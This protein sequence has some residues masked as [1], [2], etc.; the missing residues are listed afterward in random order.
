MLAANYTE[1]RSSMKKFLD[2]VENRNQTILIKRGSS[3]GS[4][5]MS[6]QEY[7]SLI[8][9]I[10]LLKSKANAA[11]LFESIKQIEEGNIITSNL[12]DVQ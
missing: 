11:W 2:D 10:H 4:V 8:E 6:L 1:F 9:T 3:K 12:I 7:N 5:V